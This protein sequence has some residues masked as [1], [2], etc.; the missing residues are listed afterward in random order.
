MFVHINR[1]PDE[2]LSTRVLGLPS[3]NISSLSASTKNLLHRAEIVSFD[4]LQGDCQ[5]VIRNI[6]RAIGGM[7]DLTILELKSCL[8]TECFLDNTSH[9]VDVELPM[10][11]RLYLED[12]K[13]LKEVCRGPPPLGF[14]EKLIEFRLFR[15]PQ[16]HNI[17]PRECKLPNL[18]FLTIGRYVKSNVV[19]CRAAALFSIS[20]ARSLTQLEELSINYIEEL[21]QIISEEDDGDDMKTEIIPT[22]HSSHLI[23]PYL[24][25][26]FVSYCDKLEYIFP[27][28]CVEGLKQLQKIKIFSLS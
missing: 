21:K 20:V 28:S 5:N 12:M 22:S 2:N 6:I 16:L 9:Q 7:N 11:V 13:N 10:L 26:L 1:C 14:F 3:I 19:S 4:G 24:K 8:E 17:F 18:K 23:F 25:R 15:C 27:I